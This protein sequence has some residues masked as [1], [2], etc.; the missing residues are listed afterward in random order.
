[1]ADAESATL[2]RPL[3]DDA[4]AQQNVPPCQLTPHVDRGGPMTATATHF[5]LA[6]FGV[7]RSHNRPNTSND[8]SFSKG[9]FKTLTYQPR[10]PKRFGCIEDA[11][12]FCRCFFDRYNQDHHHAGI[13]S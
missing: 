6:D 10:L 5:L 3:F 4:V 1:M 11:R 9:H 7:T 13:A 2:F 8:N 12:S